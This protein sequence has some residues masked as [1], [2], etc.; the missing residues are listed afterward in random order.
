MTREKTVVVIGGGV[1]GL[2]A[3]GILAKHGYRVRLF[4]ANGKLGGCCGGTTLGGYT[5]NDGAVFLLLRGVLDRVFEHLGLSREE[6]LPLRRVTANSTTWLPDG[7]VVTHGDGVD[8]TVEG[9]STPFDPGRTREE[10]QAL[11]RS[12]TPLYRDVVELMFQP[13]SVPRML[14]KTWRYLPRLRRT[15]ADDL[16]R[17]VSHPA[18]RAALAGTVLY[19]GVPAER[20]PAIGLLGL[21]ASILEG[22]HLPVGGMGRIPQALGTAI[23]RYGGEINLHAPA[24]RILVEGGRVRGVRIEGLGHVEAD[25]VISTV[26]GMLTLSRLLDP[27]VVPPALG[28][29]ARTAELSQRSVNVQLGLRNG[30]N[31]PSL[32]LSVLPPMEEHHRY[33]ASGSREREWLAWSVPTTVDPTIAPPGGSV[34]EVFPP[35]DQQIPFSAWDEARKTEVVQSTLEMLS[36]HHPIDVAVSRV[37]GPGEFERDMHLPQGALYGLSTAT[38]P[39]SLFPCRPGIAG[40]YLA[41]QTTFPGYSVPPVAVSGLHAAA[42][43]ERDLAGRHAAAA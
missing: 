43:V 36:R 19:S 32:N 1:S 41:G 30:L 8:V 22:T 29:K 12:W 17:S 7:S 27:S 18:V 35:I 9:G 33:F 6:L 16:R 26:S 11:V 15:M 28:R 2:T 42:A 39:L 37:R 13:P 31:A 14:G 21:V 10:I 4:E 24:E 40:L 25:A 38:S 34:V 3:G 5:F 23:S 20:S